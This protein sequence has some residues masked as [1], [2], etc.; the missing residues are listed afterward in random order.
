M[1]IG[2]DALPLASQCD[3]EAQQEMVYSICMYQAL[4]SLACSSARW[5]LIYR[6][7]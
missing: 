1:Y 2:M 7:P 3:G 5:S 6:V 4:M